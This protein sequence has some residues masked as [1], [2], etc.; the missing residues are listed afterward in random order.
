MSPATCASWEAG[1]PEWPSNVARHSCAAVTAR[2]SWPET[3]ATAPAPP[4]TSAAPQLAG[5]AWAVPRRTSL[6][7]QIRWPIGAGDGQRG[8]PGY[9]IPQSR[10]FGGDDR[11]HPGLSRVARERTIDLWREAGR[12][13]PAEDRHRGLGHQLPVVRSEPAKFFRGDVGGRFV[14]HGGLP[15][16]RVGH[17]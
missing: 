7:R 8:A 6:P 13:T 14:E 17:L 2:T 9:A 15:A 11:R 3:T 1:R 10:S 5:V 12:E 16:F 4:A